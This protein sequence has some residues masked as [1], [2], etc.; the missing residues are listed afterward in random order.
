MVDLGEDEERFHTF[1]LPL[2][3]M[4]M[5]VCMKE[6]IYLVNFIFVSFTYSCTGKFGTVNGRR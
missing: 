3:G 2:T 6:V 5:V 4:K 1:M